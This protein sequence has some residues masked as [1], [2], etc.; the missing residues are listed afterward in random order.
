MKQD[1]E[2][3]YP[4][5]CPVC[6]KKYRVMGRRGTVPFMGTDYVCLNKK[7]FCY[8]NMEEVKD[9]WQLA[10]GKKKVFKA[11]ADSNARIYNLNSIDLVPYRR[12]GRGRGKREIRFWSSS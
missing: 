3:L 11:K 10:E 8:I 12:S 2:F 9:A 4:D 5:T 6:G 7:C 1:G